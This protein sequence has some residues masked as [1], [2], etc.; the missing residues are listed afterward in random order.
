[1]QTVSNDPV[2]APRPAG[3]FSRRRLLKLLGAGGATVVVAGTGALSYRVYDTAALGPGRGDAYDPWQ[4][5]RETP[6]LLGAVGAAVLAPSPHNTQPWGFGIRA[7][8]VDV[9]VDAARDTGTVDPFHREQHVGIGCALENLVLACRARGLLPTVTLLPDGPA[10]P[11]IAEVAVRP[12]P[13]APSPLYDAIGDRH[14]NRGP[15]EATAIEPETLNEL[16]D[17]T[18]ADDV[19]VRWIA[20]PAPR[21]AMSRLLIDAAAALCDDDQQSRDNFAWFRGTNDDIQRYRDGLTLGG[22][23]FGPLMLAIAKLL[24]ASSRA[25]GDQ[26]WL[27]QTTTVHTA[28]AAAYGVLTSRTPDDRATQLTAGRLLERIHLAATGRGIALHHMNQVTE[29]IDRERSTGA[30]PAF[31]PRF[32]ELLPRGEQPLLTFRVGYPVRAAAPSPRR[33]AAQVV[34]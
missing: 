13:P 12:G 25:D 27:K 11:R 5:W 34:R 24:P 19:E 15:F 4:H 18:G 16:A 10:G 26:F 9:Y 28:T 21:A 30:A 7:D 2:A 3:G 23:G 14:T 33:A 20:D 8:G 31:G 32:A 1:M 22:Q 29:R 6:G 17:R